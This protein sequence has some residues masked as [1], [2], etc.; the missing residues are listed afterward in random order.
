LLETVVEAILGVKV[1]SLHTDI[2]TRTGESVIMFTL[3]E[4]PVFDA[5]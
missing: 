2:S 3:E 5:P 4:K 1:A